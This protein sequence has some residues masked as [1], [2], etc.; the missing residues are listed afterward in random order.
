MPN[1]RVRNFKGMIPAL[2]N[3]LLPNENASYAL[4]CRMHNGELSPFRKAS[5]EAENQ[6][7]G[8][9]VYDNYDDYVTTGLEFTEYPTINRCLN[10]NAFVYSNPVTFPFNYGLRILSVDPISRVLRMVPYG[11][12]TSGTQLTLGVP[13]GPAV[14]LNGTVPAQRSQFPTVRAYCA[15]YVNSYGEESAPG[16]VS[17]TIACNEGDV[18]RMSIAPSFTPSSPDTFQIR[19]IRLYRT[20]GIYENGEQLGNK[21]NTDYHLIT[22]FAYTPGEFE[23]NDDL[24]ADKVAADLLLSR[25]YFMPSTLDVAAIAELESGFLAIAYRNGELRI[26]ERFQWHAHPLR[27]RFTIP[28][29]IESMVSFNDTL[30][31]TCYSGPSYRVT[32]VP[33]PAGPEV[34]IQ[35]YSDMYASADPRTLVRSN[36]GAIFSSARGLVAL[37]R[38]KQTI[39]TQNWINSTQWSE[40]FKK[41]YMHWLSG[42]LLC[43][44]GVGNNG[45]AWL[46]D[47]PDDIS[48]QTPFGKLTY[49]DDE[50]LPVTPQPN[51]LYYVQ[52]RNAIRANNNGTRWVWDGLEREPFDEADAAPYVWRS[53]LYVEPGSTTYAAAKIVFRKP[54]ENGV[55]FTLIGDGLIRYS[56]MVYR[57]TPF[58]IPHLFKAMNWMFEL[59][60]RAHIQE[61][62][63]ATSMTELANEPK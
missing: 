33:K 61:V 7:P 32:V 40:S 5:I 21:F 19:K 3:K 38:E 6:A 57:D 39:I 55:R 34:D 13:P 51:G 11:S 12:T 15:T 23:F 9:I 54:S 47:V 26:S 42:Y 27:N 60:G 45:P 62:H 41:D 8:E 29:R 35:P 14:I 16:Q 2:E 46:M 28:Q 56:R 50:L 4:N 10:Q 48:G 30:F 20:M 37:S 44:P 18:V 63:I 58:R 25:E 43:R 31:I 49:V 1:I 17:V 59:S 22:E 36:F 24:L 52:C 53:K